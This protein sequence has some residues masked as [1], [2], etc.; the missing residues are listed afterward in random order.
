MQKRAFVEHL[1]A[2]ASQA[3]RGYLVVVSMPRHAAVCKLTALSRGKRHKDGECEFNKALTTPSKRCKYTKCLNKECGIT[4]C[5]DCLSKVAE[6]LRRCTNNTVEPGYL[7]TWQICQVAQTL[8]ISAIVSSPAPGVSAAVW[9]Y[10]YSCTAIAAVPLYSRLNSCTAIAASHT[11]V[12]RPGC[13]ITCRE[14]LVPRAPS[15]M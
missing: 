8:P 7:A 2:V 15:A 12:S 14:R 5:V 4:C 11:A 13:V 3:S 1:S 10:R 6:V 9:P